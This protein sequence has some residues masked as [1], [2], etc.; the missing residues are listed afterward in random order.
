[1]PYHSVGLGDRKSKRE[2]DT[3][4]AKNITETHF[5]T[6]GRVVSVNG[7]M[8]TIY[9]VCLPTKKW[10]EEIRQAC[11][12]KVK[13]WLNRQFPADRIPANMRIRVR[14]SPDDDVFRA[15]ISE[16]FKATGSGR[17][18]TITIAPHRGQLVFDVRI[19]HIAEKESIVPRRPAE[20]PPKALLQLCSEICQMLEVFD[21][22]RRVL[23]VVRIVATSSDGQALGADSLDAPSRRLPIIVEY[24]AGIKTESSLTAQLAHDLLGIAH[25]AHVTTPDALK[26]F[27][28][29]CG[30]QALSEQYITIMW[31]QPIKSTV[32]ATSQP[33]REQ[34]AAMIIDAATMQPE[35]PIQAPPRAAFGR[36]VQSPVASETGIGAD[37]A[38]LKKTIDLLHKQI[39]EKQ[40]HIDQLDEIL[41]QTE[42]ERDEQFDRLQDS[43]DLSELAEAE[44]VRLEAIIQKLVVDKIEF[45]KLVE[46]VAPELQMRNVLEALHK[47]KDT[48]S[49][50]K[51]APTAFETGSKLHGPHPGRLY[52]DLRDLNTVVMEW[53]KGEFPFEGLRSR[54]LAAGLT[55]VP[56]IGV[57][58]S[59][60]HSDFYSIIWN[61]KP[62]LLSAHLAR[63]TGG[64]QIS[65][66]YMHIDQNLKTIV[67]GKVVRHGPDRTSD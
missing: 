25:I 2:A 59:Q 37:I 8:N 42:N 64:N 61:G 1:M 3:P 22:E 41:E 34:I 6:I 48:C 27:N 45:E 29:Y 28:A 20:V 53:R 11:N 51:F 58:T 19:R 21:A 16:T 43:Q 47:A 33:K 40:F 5:A 26:A 4:Q 35:L 57:S 7:V 15:E 46:R 63:G 55:F 44:N 12:D 50:L 39:D 32:I 62:V 10:S 23:P 54:C 66:I 65:R 52:R 49:H 9:A 24:V 30:S 36:Q 13:D 17:T 56:N 60:K 67:I 31:P 38:S 14:Q 18:I